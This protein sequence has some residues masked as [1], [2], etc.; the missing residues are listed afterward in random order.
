MTMGDRI[1]VMKDGFIQQVDTPQTLYDK[2]CNKF[3]AGFIGSP[4][5]NFINC[6]ITKKD[7]MFTANFGKY[8]LEIPKGKT[9]D[10]SFDKYDGKEV[11][12]GVR[13]EAI[14]D[15]ELFISSFKELAVEAEVDIAELMGSEIFIYMTVEGNN[16]VAKVPPR[17]TYK[18]GDVISIAIDMNKAHFF[19]A[20]TELTICH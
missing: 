11:V 4:Q 9:V 15:D 14:H 17:S 18:P 6:M 16:L 20:E 1:V 10:G 5:M 8:S 3:V 2:P 7:D 13:P 19:D 12:L